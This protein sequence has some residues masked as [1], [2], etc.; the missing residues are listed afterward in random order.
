MHEYQIARDILKV[1]LESAENH[2]A[3][4]VTAVKVRLGAGQAVSQ[5]TMQTCFQ[6]VAQDTIARD[7]ALAVIIT[8]YQ[9]QCPKCGHQFETLEWMTACPEC[10]AAPVQVTGGSEVVVESIEVE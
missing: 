6:A 4:K 10:E 9:A 3:G 8:P 1:A 7:A 5:E 2:G